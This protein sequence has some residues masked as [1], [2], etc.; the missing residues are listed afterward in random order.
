MS[1]NATMVR[2]LA[3]TGAAAVV[4][5][6]R[7]GADADRPTRT[8]LPVGAPSSM[9]ESRPIG[10]AIHRDERPQ[11][12]HVQIADLDRDGLSDVLATDAGRNQVVWIRQS[13]AGTFVERTVG[14]P[15]AAPAHVQAIDVDLDGDLDLV[16]ASLGVLFP[17]NSRVGAVIVFENDG[18]EQFRPHTI[19]DKTARVADAEA[20][21][22]DD[23]GDLDIAVAGFG[24]DN[25]E[26]SWLEN[27]G[28][29][30]FVT[31]VLLRLSG[32][33]NAVPAALVPAGHPDIVTL[34]SQEWEEV[35]A[36]V[37]DGHGAFVP[38][39]VW[40]S[41]NADFG[42]SWI[43]LA[44]LD[45][46]DAIDIILSNGDAFDYAPANS[47]PWHGVQWLKNI[48]DRRF[49][50]RRIADL[51]GASSP[52][53]ADLDGDGDLDIIA[54]SAYN[55]WDD[56]SALSMVLLENDGRMNFTRRQI[57][58]ALTHLI[59]VAIGDI[60][61]NNRPD[62]VTGGMHISRPYKNMSRVTAWINRGATTP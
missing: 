49:E 35:W 17:S 8:A 10:D 48:G 43:T 14:G 54:V 32:P 40:G 50:Y 55:N 44:D 15:V 23:D 61:G 4:W 16:V 56:P 41:T 57:R 18:A 62:L 39:M 46:D 9:F 6:C 38:S 19:I 24:Y 52:Q 11:I 2:V 5:G 36:F 31:H 1:V 12:S 7:S 30:R 3:C 60:D 27:I 51:S 47:R 42:S 45:Q 26:T 37:N 29:W 25:G 59:T 34:V 28:N 22:L 13:P 20:A 21:D 33:I 58:T 53:A